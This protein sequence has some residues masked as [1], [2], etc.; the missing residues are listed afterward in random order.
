MPLL[1]QVDVD[2]NTYH[3]C[4]TDLGTQV[5]G[6]ICRVLSA[7]Y[8]ACTW[9]L[10]PQLGPPPGV[11]FSHLCTELLQ[12]LPPAPPTPCPAGAGGFSLTKGPI[13]SSLKS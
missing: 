8:L 12:P 1:G 4:P 9:P 11:A 2:L 5:L 13:R 6:W 3:F 10:N 7:H